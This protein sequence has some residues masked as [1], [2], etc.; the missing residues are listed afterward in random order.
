MILQGFLRI[1]NF[2]RYVISF[3]HSF[4]LGEGLLPPVQP[5]LLHMDNYTKTDLMQTAANSTY[6]SSLLHQLLYRK[7]VLEEE[8]VPGVSAQLPPYLSKDFF[9]IIKKV[10]TESPL[11]TSLTEKYWS[12]LR[13]EDCVTMELNIDKG[14]KEFR[15]CRAELASPTTDWS[16]S[17]SL[18][19]Q[20]G[21]PPD[22]SSFLW[23]MLLDLLCTQE[24]LHKMVA[25]PSPL[26]KLCK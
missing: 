19:R 3:L 25:S 4:S 5:L 13:T 11:S 24:R 14:R 15:P 8:D 7:H 9:N 23:K 18:C 10:K 12:R 1:I 22:L 2:S 20:H 21:I 17:W 6:H 26:C 16:P